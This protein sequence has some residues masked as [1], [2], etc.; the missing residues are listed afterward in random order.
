MSNYKVSRFLFYS[1]LLAFIQP[2]YFLYY[3]HYPEGL[4]LP[5]GILHF[6]EAS[7]I[8]LSTQIIQMMTW[9][10]YIFGG[11]CAFGII[12]RLSSVIFFLIIFVMF[13][14]SYSF[15]YNPH[16]YMP[17]TLAAFALTLKPQQSV[18]LI[19]IIFCSVFFSAG[20]SKLYSTG[21]SWISPEI[22]E[23]FLLRSQILYY[24][25]HPLAQKLFLSSFLIEKPFLISLLAAFCLTLEVLSPLALLS[26][27][28]ALPIVCALLLMQAGIY[29]TIL[30]D[31]K[32]Y[33]ALYCFWINWE[34][35]L[36][37]MPF[38]ILTRDPK[39]KSVDP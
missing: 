2:E 34:Y 6:F 28:L 15:G 18:M 14:I 24:D 23:N 26:S 4:Y 12:Y 1:I 31:F 27:S 13:N 29:L 11:L 35:V 25:M 10:F 22:L 37:S 38:R 3:S 32:L 20:I 19:K 39:A 21:F 33:L 7:S 17:I 5:S 9:C 30:V 36:D 8:Q 16:V